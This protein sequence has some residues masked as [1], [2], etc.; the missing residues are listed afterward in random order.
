MLPRTRACAAWLSAAASVPFF[1]RRSR[2]RAS[3]ALPRCTAS[4]LM[5]IIVTCSPAIAATCAM[6]LPMVPAPMTAI[7]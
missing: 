2:L 1:T 3:V 7:E 5:S 4:S 6:P